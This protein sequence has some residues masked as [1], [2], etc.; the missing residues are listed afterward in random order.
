MYR[1]SIFISVSI[2]ILTSLVLAPFAVQAKEVGE[3]LPRFADE[4]AELQ[5]QRPSF[6]EK[7]QLNPDGLWY[8]TTDTTRTDQV[9][10]FNLVNTTG[11]PDEFG[12]TW[13]DTVVEAWIDASDGTSAVLSPDHTDLIA[14]PFDFKYYENTYD[15]LFIS[16]Y[17]F[18][19]FDST[20]LNGS[21]QS[22]IPSAD[23]PNDVIAPNWMPFEEAEGVI[24]YKTGGTEPNRWFVV[25]WNTVKELDGENYYTFQ[26]ILFESGDIVFNYH[27]MPYTGLCKSSGI[28]D[29]TG[30]DGLTITMFCDDILPDHSVRIYRPSAS[31]RAK[32]SPRRLGEFTSPDSEEIFQIQVTNT[33]DI[34]A[35]T[36]DLSVLSDWSH[37]LYLMDGIT[38]LTDTD[39]DGT[40]DTGI[41]AMGESK[42]VVIK[43][44]T[45]DTA[46]L[47]NN[48]T[49]LFTFTSSLD[50]TVSK[51][52]SIDLAVPAPFA[53]VYSDFSDG[54]MKIQL[55]QPEQQ[56]DKEVTS[57]FYYG[58]ETAVAETRFGSLIYL[59]YKGRRISSDPYIY[60]HEIEYI[61]LDHNGNIIKPIS[62]LTDL[63]TATM[64]T[65]VSSI[66]VASAPDGHIGITWV[67]RMRNSS[68]EYNYNTF[69]AILDS[70]GNVSL[71]PYN[72]TENNLWGS[73]TESPRFYTP[74][75]SAN[76]D[77]RFFFAWEKY[78]Y[79]ST[80]STHDIYYSI[81]Q[82]NGTQILGV[83]NFT[84][85][86]PG[87]HYS[88]SLASLGNKQMLLSWFMD[89]QINS[90]ILDTSGNRKNSTIIT[91]LGYD[92]GFGLDSILLSNQK[93][94]LAWTTYTNEDTDKP[95]IAYTFLD[96][97][98]LE[99]TI[100]TGILENSKSI[101]GNDYV[102]VTRDQFGHAVLTWMEYY[103][104]PGYPLYY[105]L[106]G[107]DGSILTEPMIYKT[108]YTPD[109]VIYTS[110]HGFGNTTHAIPIG[111]NMLFL[112]VIVRN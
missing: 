58:S 2:L 77:N 29:S 23:P 38:P 10:S 86:T 108:D 45:P 53:Q 19:S 1:K 3:N 61:I 62:K 5:I 80:G 16:L 95:Q 24:K 52:G 43:I 65:Y 63:S 32:V 101:T 59:W 46:S 88:P 18:V 48:E 72:L 27:Q 111:D 81:F 34:G 103:P 39:S 96:S 92:W 76:E 94:I 17:G 12:Y 11:G 41:L 68:S 60:A 102:S 28:E 42:D 104:S 100:E 112:P 4:P 64:S 9:E 13:D 83:T 97:N 78:T 20:N 51:Q 70:M 105:A 50:P 56:T 44:Q 57:D 106:I 66:A 31:A 35:D 79:N 15:G 36:F 75:V 69:I 8:R 37:S 55:N 89:D 7:P 85:S 54:A 109:N 47:G 82:T 87:Y 21:W 99:Q 90:V 71:G 30:L 49:A 25:E 33:G 22:E 73:Y 110:L 98:T 74:R 26:A 6:H 93:I 40:P 67:Q 107:N 14:L 91:D 84:E